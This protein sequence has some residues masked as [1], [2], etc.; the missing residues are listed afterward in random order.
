M[1]MTVMTERGESPVGELASRDVFAFKRRDRRYL[2]P[3]WRNRGRNHEIRV[4]KPQ[5]SQPINRGIGKTVTVTVLAKNGCRSRWASLP[6]SC[7]A[8]AWAIIRRAGVARKSN[9]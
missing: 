9:H 8:L 4:P 2:L 5:R 6:L 1:T 7:Y 3:I